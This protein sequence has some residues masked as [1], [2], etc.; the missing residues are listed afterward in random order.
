MQSSSGGPP[1]RVHVPVWPP[2]VAVNDP[3]QASPE[4]LSVKGLIVPHSPNLENAPVMLGCE[5]GL[6]TKMPLKSD[7]IE[8]PTQSLK[9]KSRLFEPPPCKTLVIVPPFGQLQNSGAGVAKSAHDSVAGSLSKA[10]YSLNEVWS[11]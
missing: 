3:S 11:S 4:M 9:V 1:A 2:Q 7:E 5:S 8:S 10:R 6:A